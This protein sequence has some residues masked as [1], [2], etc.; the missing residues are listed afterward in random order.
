MLVYVD[1]IS[2]VIDTTVLQR[3]S[4]AKITYDKLEEV[5]TKE[6]IERKLSKKNVERSD[7]LYLVLSV[8]SYFSPKDI[9]SKIFNISIQYRNGLLPFSQKNLEKFYIFSQQHGGNFKFDELQTLSGSGLGYNVEW[10]MA[11]VRN[12]GQMPQHLVFRMERAYQTLCNQVIQEFYKTSET[13][14]QNNEAN[15]H[16]EDKDVPKKHNRKSRNKMNNATEVTPPGPPPISPEYTDANNNT[17]SSTTFTPVWNYS[18]TVPTSM[19]Y[20]DSI[21]VDPDEGIK[22][23]NIFIDTKRK[24]PYQVKL[25]KIKKEIKLVEKYRYV[26]TGYK[27][28][29][30][31]KFYRP[32]II[33]RGGGCW[34]EN[35]LV[36]IYQKGWISCKDVEVGDQ[37]YTESGELSQILKVDTMFCEAARLKYVNGIWFTPGHPVKINNTWKR[38]HEYANNKVEYPSEV[39]RVYDLKLAEEHSIPLMKNG[40]RVT[41]ATIGKFDYEWRRNKY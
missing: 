30:C 22:L 32:I 15:I 41:C 34:E 18:T 14:R 10:K 9:F 35:A 4:K 40:T 29:E 16:E 8:K 37:V 19:M 1:I 6:E 39:C 24:E 31:D 33:Y 5:L 38:A 27:C 25:V 2:L 20:V 36:N 11:F 3:V 7:K 23:V 26:N 13:I 21:R 28:H 12:S 17:S